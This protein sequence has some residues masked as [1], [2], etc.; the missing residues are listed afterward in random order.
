MAASAPCGASSVTAHRHRTRR[1]A[2]AAAAW[3]TY[4]SE[5]YE[6]QLGFLFPIYGK[7]KI[8]VPNHQTAQVKHDNMNQRPKNEIL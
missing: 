5:K 1:E 8:H 2:P 4:P 6:S 3:Y 7:N